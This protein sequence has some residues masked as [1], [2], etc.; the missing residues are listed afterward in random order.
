MRKEILLLG[1]SVGFAFGIECKDYRVREGDTLE[2]ISKREGVDIQSLRS[3]NKGL[4]EGKLKVG[5]KLCIPVKTKSGG[6]YATYEV[7]RGDTLE[8]IADSF[9]TDARTLKEFNNLKDDRLV[10]GQKIK[11]PARNAA[12]PKGEEAKAS[13]KREESY[14]LY[15]VKR[16]GKLSDIS[17]ATGVPL[18]E[19]ERLN[20]ELKGK[21]LKA[22]TRVKVPEGS[23]SRRGDEDYDIYKVKRGGKLSHV[24][25]ATGIPIKELERLNPELRDKW[26]EPGTQVRVPKG[27]Q[28]ERG[29]REEKYET[30]RV[31]RGA[32]LEHVAKN[33][34]IP[35]REL[36]RLNPEL[37][38]KW[39]PA[40]TQVKIPPKEDSK[41]AKAE[42]AYGVYILEKRSRLRDVSEATGV[43]L[44][45]LERLNPELKGKT[46]KAGTRV[47]V[48]KREER[49]KIPQ[50]TT[51]Q[52]KEER[53]LFGELER[54]SAV[55]S[56]SIPKSINIQLPVEG[57]VAKVPKGLEISA[58]CSSPIKVV[59]EGR[60]IYSGGDLQAYGNMIIVE[61]E[62]F[63]SLYAYN[64]ANLVKRGDRVSKGQVIARL[65][66]K[67]NSEDCTLRFEL[68]NK[69]GIP[70]DP[71]EY[72]KDIQ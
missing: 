7:K 23:L 65:G 28:E 30:Y 27:A 31:K 11:I 29:D 13:S 35:L 37:K 17:K 45:E 15:R 52:R 72:L 51:P 62:G 44:K 1:I 61:H 40:G 46:L 54:G 21:T 22:G 4:Q 60:V 71:T 25:K 57:K 16:G 12:K 68:R 10:E 49:A 18:K 56:P 5:Q 34:G 19:L 59:E 41:R 33:T 9:G 38:G 2:R 6:A 47:K 53:S 42:E 26:L 8:K 69:E 24:A 14:D 3:A 43:P 32:K 70:L 67:S 48:P 58:P 63:I 55:I 50:E 66:K 39:L 20:P 36:E 64:E